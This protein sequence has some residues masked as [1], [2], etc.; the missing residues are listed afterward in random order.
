MS[1]TTP[2]RGALRRVTD[3]PAVL[4][5]LA[6]VLSLVVGGILI[7]A[8]D[9]ETRGAAGYFFARPSDTLAAAWGAGA[10]AYAAMFRGAILNYRADALGDMLR[11]LTETLTMATP[12]ITASLG[13]ALAFRAGLFNIGAQGQILIAAGLSGYVGFAWQLPTALHLLLVVVAA[14]LGG[15]VWG[16]LA[17]WIK[18]RTGAH[19]VI[20]TIMLNYVAV[21]L[22]A[23]ALSTPAMQRPG[24]SDPISPQIAQSAHYPPLFGPDYRTHLGLLVALAAAVGVW[25]LL[26]RST[27]GFGLKATGANPDAARTAGIDTRRAVVVAMVVAGALAGL[28]GAAQVN[29]TQFVVVGGIA[30]SIG[31][32]AITVA[33]LGRSRALGVVLAALLFGAFRA[34]GVAMQSQT[35]TPVD[36]VLV[37]QSLIVLFIAA[38]PLVRTVFGLGGRRRRGPAAPGAAPGGSSLTAGSSL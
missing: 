36:I 30:G 16:G 27:I 32:D 9:P 5:A 34:G 12:L 23:W 17:G 31:F 6:I 15:A 7:A 10:D 24:S 14:L 33:L 13:V 19:E 20:L 4:S 38:P 26:E 11:P 18:A 22:L 1:P 35:G 37:V 25:W 2:D 8:T 21:Y 29:G 3:A 28:S